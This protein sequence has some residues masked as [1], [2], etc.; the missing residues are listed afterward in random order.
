MSHGT[1]WKLRIVKTH[2]DMI[3]S[4]M[5]VPLWNETPLIRSNY[6]SR[7][8]G[9]NAYLKLEN[10]HPSHSFKYR[11]LSLFVQRAKEKHGPSVHLIVASGGNAG[12]AG[13]CAANVLGLRCTVY[14]PEG[15][16]ERTLDLLKGENAETVVI[17]K[18][19]AEALAAAQEAIEVEENAVMIPA[20]DDPTVWEGHGSMISEISRQ[21]AAKPDA[22]FCSVGGGGLLG[23][24]ILGCKEAGWDDVPIIALETTG[25]N[26]FHYSIALNRQSSGDFARVLPAHVTVVE[27]QTENIMLAHFSEFSSM[28]S[29]SLGASQPAAKVAKMALTREGGI[30]CVSVPDELSM[31]ASC[32]FTCD[33]KLLVELACATTL[34]PAYSP[35]LFD[36][37]VPGP[38]SLEQER[39]VIF[40]VCGGFKVSNDDIEF[41][42]AS[43]EQNATGWEVS[44]NEGEKLIVEKNA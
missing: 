7:K 22:I 26:C 17:G 35:A 19:Y 24:I 20:Y 11:G 18:M 3:Q 37:L 4:S 23:G 15:V 21:L 40:V 6:I 33:H 41:Y 27:D 28:A 38:A 2:H 8:L 16:A 10:L 32:L 42:K 31:Q 36:R 30:T 39:T 44:I 5:S 14:V 1:R 9:C 12:L 13:A 43:I 29:G 25:S 34:T